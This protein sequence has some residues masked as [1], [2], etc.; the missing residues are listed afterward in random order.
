M[1]PV[2]LRKIF[3]ITA[4]LAAAG[5]LMWLFDDGLGIG[6]P[7]N[8]LRNW[9]QFG[10]AALHGVLVYNPG[11]FDAVAQPQVYHGMSPYYLY[12]VYF[13][14]QLFGWTGLGTLSFH[15]LLAVLVLW[16]VWSLLGKGEFALLVAIAV[17][18]T[19]G[20]GRWQK[21]IDPN[22][23]SVLLGIPYAAI[24]TGLLK[25]SKL[26]RADF[27]GLAFLTIAFVPLNWTT[28]WLLAPF[29]IFLLLSTHIRRATAMAFL[30]LAA[31]GAMAFVF[32]SMHAKSGGSGTGGHFLGGYTWGNYGYGEGLTTSRAFT[33]IFFVAVVGLLPLLGIWLVAGWRKSH[34]SAR[35]LL[36]AG[37]PLAV[38]LLEI[39]AMRNYFGNHP[40]MSAPVV[41]AGLVFSCA[42]L[43]ENSVPPGPENCGRCQ[44]QWLLAA[45]C[46][47]YA[48]LVL[49]FYRTNGSE[50]RSLTSLVRHETA[51][52]DWIVVVK[53][54]DPTTAHLA[55]RLDETL[56]RHIALVDDVKD[57]PGGQRLA[58]LT[59]V[60]MNGGQLIAE[61]TAGAD[62]LDAT[63]QKAADWFNRTISHRNPGDRLEIPR[64]F[65]LYRPVP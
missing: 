57:L 21:S 16:G 55:D 2:P 50:G 11:G 41:I 10:P 40:W 51:R 25:K 9:Q 52:T 44:R 23:I 59:S 53:N 63:L 14:T 17:I 28:A 34:G 61:A 45:A 65:Y 29:G 24:V 19:P 35:K 36:N 62:G 37:L 30:S 1:I 31:T 58:I 22:V 3:F 42:L 49:A 56:D 33:R 15:L 4:V 64:H 12:P 60:P 46:F 20:Y 5:W 47:I 54:L 6:W 27:F 8:A 43:A 32:I 48:L 13:C 38:A 18:L 7:S 26:Q 39:A